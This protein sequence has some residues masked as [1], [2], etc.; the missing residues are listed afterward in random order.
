MKVMTLA[1]AIGGI[2][3]DLV[4]GAIVYQPKRAKKWKHSKWAMW[5][6]FAACLCL[7]VGV[8]I[9]T[10]IQTGQEQPGVESPA[11]Q[12][13]FNATVIEIT[14]DSI[15]V[16]CYD[17][18]VGGISVGK[19]IQVS[20]SNISSERVPNLKLGDN[21]RILYIG[22]VSENEKELLILE[23]TISIFLLDENGEV[24]IEDVN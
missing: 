21:I 19:K 24:I 18:I 15:L 16:E 22:N 2:D 8:F 5:G 17:S 1:E 13:C 23:N 20:T 9:M 4:S 12:G 10:H 7:V 6:A 3:D 14:D 11:G